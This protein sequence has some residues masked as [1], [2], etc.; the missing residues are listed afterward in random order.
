MISWDAYD[1]ERTTRDFEFTHRAMQN[2]NRIVS[3]ADFAD[4]DSNM[5]FRYLFNGMELVSFKDYLKRYLYSRAEIQEPFRS[6][7]DEIYRDII[8]NSFAENH[9]PQS[10]APTKKR[11]SATIKSWLNQKSARR[12]TIF[13]L[14]FGLRMPSEDVSEFLVKVLKEESFDFSDP[15]ETIFWY[16]YQTHAPFSKAQDLFHRMQQATLVPKISNIQIINGIPQIETEQQL[17]DYLVQIQKE[18]TRTKHRETALREFTQLL[19][20]SK[21]IIA[22][23]YSNDTIFSSHQKLWCAEEITSA[24]VEKVLC[25]GIP[26]NKSGNLEKASLST[27]SEH[28]QQKRLSRQ[29]ID[30]LLKQKNAVD[31]FDLI[32]LLFFIYSQEVEPDWPEERHLRF[33]DEINEILIRC[34]MLE[35]YPVNPYESFVLMC[36]LADCPLAVYSEIWE[37]SYTTQSGNLIPK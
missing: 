25:S 27:L 14:G 12:D 24:D 8:M 35:L 9:A 21:Q 37:L 7:S 20:H 6:V 36:L 23:L 34:G 17:L 33:I 5:I 10:F 19:D 26:L 31:R 16:C 4:M 28:F 3:S 11:W 30:C 29:R 13:L 22:R 1:F 2:M 32:T 15:E 18:N